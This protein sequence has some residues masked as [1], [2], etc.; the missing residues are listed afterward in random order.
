MKMELLCQWWQPL[1]GR[2]R[3]FLKRV[4][5][6]MRVSVRIKWKVTYW[7][8]VKVNEWV[9]AALRVSF[10]V[11]GLWLCWGFRLW[12]IY[13]L[14]LGWELGFRDGLSLGWGIGLGFGK[15]LLLGRLRVR[16]GARLNYEV[17]ITAKFMR[18]IPKCMQNQ[19]SPTDRSQRHSTVRS[20]NLIVESSITSS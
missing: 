20:P 11:Q 7:L 1:A 5:D 15:W 6:E 14:R 12:L 17:K 19:M 2:L 3:V 16:V 10:Q 13:S 18:F 4:A 9:I 8:T